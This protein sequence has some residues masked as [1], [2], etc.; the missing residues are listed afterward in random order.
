MVNEGIQSE[1]RENRNGQILINN[2]AINESDRP[3]KK[4]NINGNEISVTVT[5]DIQT[6]DLAPGGTGGLISGH[7]NGNAHGSGVGV[8]GV[9]RGEFTSV[10]GAS[11][12]RQTWL[13]T[14]RRGLR[15]AITGTTGQIRE[16]A[17]GTGTGGITLDDTAL[18]NENRKEIKT[19]T[20]TASDKSEF[21]SRWG[22]TEHDGFIEELA[23]ASGATDWGTDVQG[24]ILSRGL[25]T[26]SLGVGQ[27]LKLVTEIDI[28]ADGSGLTKITDAG[29]AAANDVLRKE[30]ATIGL[31]EIALGQN[32]TAAARTDTALGNESK[33]RVVDREK[34]NDNLRIETGFYSDEFQTD[35]IQ[36][37]GVFTNN[38]NLFYRAVIKEF[39]KQDF[40]VLCGFGL[41]IR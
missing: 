28:D 18:T 30:N 8:S 31:Q 2:R 40:R 13:R 34:V 33:R 7:P 3:D 1:V 12:S 22:V 27:E 35:D 32:G 36:E 24:N 15:D 20:E 6:A 17:I 5:T 38:G 25:E 4:I 26:V 19:R 10:S 14:G 41:R 23:L 37:F 39:T 21:E 16:Q 29:I 9:M 11:S